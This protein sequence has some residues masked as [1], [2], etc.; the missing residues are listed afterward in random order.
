[1]DNI[2][3][4]IG[5]KLRLLEH[6]VWLKKKEEWYGYGEYQVLLDRI[7]KQLGM[8]EPIGMYE[9]K[10]SRFTH[11]LRC[12][13]TLPKHDGTY[14]RKKYG[15]MAMKEWKD[16][17]WVGDK[18]YTTWDGIYHEHPAEEWWEIIEIKE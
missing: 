12:P 10:G 6:M 8:Y 14:L 7:N 5:T 15:G 13:D 11:V 3:E 17:D 4:L 2:A 16:G 18:G 1:M 9:P